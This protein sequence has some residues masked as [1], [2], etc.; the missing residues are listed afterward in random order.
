MTPLDA[1]AARPMR[2]ALYY[3]WLYLTS[4][5]ERTILEIVRRSRHQVVIFTNEYQPHATYPEL[6]DMDVRVLR[7]VPVDRSLKSV[8]IAASRILRQKLDL[9]GFDALLIMCEGLGDLMTLRHRKIPAFC[10]CLTPLR[11]VFD[12]VYRS[13]YLGR[14][15]RLHAAAVRL[16]SLLYRWIDRRAW[17]RYRR[18]FLISEE[19]R[20]RVLAGKLAPPDKL[21]VLNPG[22]DL[23]AFTPAADAE[24]MLFVPGR[25]MWTKN[26]ELAIE[27]FRIFRAGVE[28]PERWRL[29][30]A[31]IVD[32]K[33]EPYLERLRELA[34][35]DPAI[36]FRI[37]LSDE[38]MQEGY[39]RSFATLFTA[40]NEDWGLVLI[41][42]MA[43][44]KP[45]VA[46][47]RG[48]PREI[49]RHDHDGLLAEADPEQFA[50]AIL[51]LVHEPELRR[52]L[53]ANGPASAARFGWDGFVE[54]LDSAIEAE[55]GVRSA[56][57]EVSA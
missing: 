32:R 46:V 42:S 54:R 45:V 28:D 19:I 50:A 57:A 31:G 2:I 1:N 56:A 8:A 43:T 40:F 21:R 26:L 4:G 6:Q 48:G 41:E 51:R 44:A 35:G 37:H 53:A 29:S 49:V 33:S 55:L 16:G 38:E 17:R 52:R 7:Q 36:E 24:R 11:I 3:P 39:R 20:R 13:V 15:G 27:A 9:A 23:S 30:I 5:A 18:A 34:Q 22:V 25:I 12:P 14:R 47:N 10:L